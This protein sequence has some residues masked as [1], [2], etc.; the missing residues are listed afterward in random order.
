MSPRIR[1]IL[2][3]AVFATAFVAACSNPN[4][5]A[6]ASIS[7][8]VDTVTLTATR[9]S[10]LQAPNAFSITNGTAVRSYQTIS[11]EFA[12][13]VTP[14]GQ[15]VLLPL[16]VLGLSPGTGLKPGLLKSTLSFDAITVAAQNGYITTDTVPVAVGDVFMVRSRQICSSLGLPEYGKIAVDSIDPVLQTIRFR[17]LTNENCGY[18]SLTPG[19]PKS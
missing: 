13:D 18:R 5:L 10:A 15:P 3:A 8:I 2:A 9:D 7:N 1:I 4:A 16:A 12:Y 17:A 19:L 14:G 11:F 6:P